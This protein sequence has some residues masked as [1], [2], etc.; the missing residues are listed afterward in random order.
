MKRLLFIAH[1][2]PYPP[3]KGERIRAFHE[4]RTLHRHFEIDLACLSR[5]D[6]SPK[7]LLPLREY[8]REIYVA[9][10]GGRG[11]WLRT[12]AGCTL[13]RSIT[14][15]YYDNRNLRRQLQEWSRKRRFDLVFG[16]SSAV[17]D[18]VLSVPSGAKLIDLV[19]VDSLKWRSYSQDSS[20]PLS[21]LYGREAAKV[22]RIERQ[23]ISLCDAAL[24]ISQAEARC[25]PAQDP[26]LKVVANGVDTEFFQP[27]QT[28]ASA[29]PSL[30]FAGTMDYRPNAEGVCWFANNV[31]RRLK[32]N[33]PSL[34]L[35]IV[36]RNPTKPVRLL[37]RL[38]GVVVTGSVPDVRPYFS[39]AQV[40][41]APL[42]MA[43]GVQNKVL[44]A[45][46]MA[47][48]VVASPPAL[49]GLD[50]QGCPAVFQADLPA[51][52]RR[53]IGDLLGDPRRCGELGL[54][55][56]RWVQQ[57]Y[58]WAACMQP[59]LGLCQELTAASARGVGGS[60]A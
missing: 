9:R 30:V 27:F 15:G 14:E 44:E 10:A 26:R 31:W 3:D 55:A 4:L 46:A 16:Y 49:E 56:R 40:A 38:A 51:Q 32:H 34:E 13:G 18:Y 50:L 7:Q 33:H 60:Q 57:R 35:R 2:V 41:I 12:A 42:R 20:W 24:L 53:A 17:L 43:R 5:E 48:P 52:W 23:A 36:G 45:M 54:E 1:C 58:A 21:W 11:V 28:P 39:S 59:L 37:G 8:C 22:A 47:R 29:T 25:A 6:V 19:D